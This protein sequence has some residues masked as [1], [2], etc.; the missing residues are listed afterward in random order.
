MLDERNFEGS[1][2][3]GSHVQEKIKLLGKLISGQSYDNR[4][5]S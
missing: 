1:R 5:K 2:K 3:A 4:K